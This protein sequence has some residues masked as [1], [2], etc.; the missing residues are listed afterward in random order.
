M[1]K[2][3]EIGKEENRETKIRIDQGILNHHL[4]LAYSHRWRASR[5]MGFPVAIWGALRR[6]LAY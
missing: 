5:A 3:D 2:K 6:P 4:R 1:A